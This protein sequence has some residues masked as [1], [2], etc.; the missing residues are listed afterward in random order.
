MW[1]EKWTKQETSKLYRSHFGTDVT[2]KV[3][4][5]YND[6]T[7]PEAAVLVQLRSGKI[8]L[9]QYLKSIK[10]IDTAECQFCEEYHE[11]VSHVLS[12]CVE[13]RD[14]RIEAFGQLFIWDVPA[15]LNV[16]RLAQKA[17]QFMLRTGLLDQFKG[18]L[19]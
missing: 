17:V 2:R 6:L 12:E 5:L 3:N 13:L 19:S 15:L 4:Q 1:E 7:K 11:T 18:N 10:A 14:Q 8:G 9:G 16:P